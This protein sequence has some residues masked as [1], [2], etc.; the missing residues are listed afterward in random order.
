MRC[1][2][3][4]SGSPQATSPC[5]VTG[6]PAPTPTYSP[7]PHLCA[8]TPTPVFSPR[9]RRILP[10]PIPCAP[11]PTPTCS[12]R[13]HRVLRLSLSVERDHP[14]ARGLQTGKHKHGEAPAGPRR[15]D[16]CQNQGECLPS[17]SCHREVPCCP[18]FAPVCRGLDTRQRGFSGTWLSGLLF[19]PQ[20]M[21]TGSRGNVEFLFLLSAQKAEPHPRGGA[22]TSAQEFSGNEGRGRTHSSPVWVGDGAGRVAFPAS[23]RSNGFCIQGCGSSVI[24]LPGVLSRP[25]RPLCACGE[26]SRSPRPTRVI[27]EGEGLSLS[28]PTLLSE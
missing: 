14:S 28:V 16:R 20:T 11:A 4:G 27:R 19:K 7:C 10:T 18:A 9:P 22:P 24:S 13:P 5:P 23:Y 21:F 17:T 25:S 8:P 1:S 12:P 26:D 6:A 3:F 2:S 15:S